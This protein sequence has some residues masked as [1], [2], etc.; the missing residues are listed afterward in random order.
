VAPAVGEVVDM[1][2]RH[3]PQ[4]PRKIAE[5][6]GRLTAALG[7]AAAK[8]SIQQQIDLAA[9]K[10][11]FGDLFV[12]ML[13]DLQPRPEHDDTPTLIEQGAGLGQQLGAA[14]GRRRLQA[15]ATP[16]KIEDWAGPVAGP[17]ELERNYGI[18]RSTLHDW[19]KQRAVIGLLAGQR[20]HVFPITQFIDGRPVEGLAGVVSQVGSPRTAWL[21]LVEPHPSLRGARPLDRLKAGETALVIE[22]AERDFGQS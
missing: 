1:F 21:W 15:Y 3:N 20:K 13:A 17:S 18:R 22:L 11:K 16:M 7:A 8:L 9:N 6:A 19:Q 14:E 4:T 10:E 5:R 2:V 12:A